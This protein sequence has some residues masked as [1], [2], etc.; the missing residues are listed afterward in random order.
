M[1]FLLY[2]VAA[3]T[4]VTVLTGRA[5]WL[6][7]YRLANAGVSTQ[8][9][10]TKTTC[11]DHSKIFYRFTAG[12]QSIDGYGDA[13]HGNPPC[14]TLKPGDPIQVVYLANGP[15]ANLPGDP[16]ERLVN[17]TAAIA[18]VALFL[19]LVVIFILF[20]FLRKRQKE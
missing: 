18:L 16:K 2:Y 11:G 4:A 13:G 14:N 9:L 1:T 6:P 3:A 19:P 20:I 7:Q 5:N 8:A 17:E 10:V 12:G 15:Q